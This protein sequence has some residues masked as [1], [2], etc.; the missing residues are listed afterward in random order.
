M[1][2]RPSGF[3]A[4]FWLGAMAISCG[5]QTPGSVDAFYALRYGQ[6]RFSEAAIFAGGRSDVSVP[7]AWIFYALRLDGAWILFDPGF[8][9]PRRAASF[10]VALID[11]RGL[12]RR[13]GIAPS[14]IAMVLVTHG[15]FDHASLA[16]AFPKATVIFAANAEDDVRRS[17]GSS[18]DPARIRI[19]NT[20]MEVAPGLTM[21]EIGGHSRGSS[22]V[23]L[24]DPSST[25]LFAGDE[26]YLGE[27]WSLP[28]ANG[29]TVDPAANL[30]FLQQTHELAA[31][32]GL[33]VL[34]AHDPAIVPDEDPIRRL[35]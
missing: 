10:K 20:T 29:S 15:H 8:E 26:A 23:Y 9:D 4:A 17:A 16:F 14:D 3:L 18:F 5:A 6:S 30:R 7:F 28:R 35:K 24:R 22:V 34:T 19:F 31:L 12:L 27:N 11:P 33:T 2:V 21:V 25:W 1:T 13:I 32:G